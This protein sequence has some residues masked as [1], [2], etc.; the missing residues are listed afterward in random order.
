VLVAVRDVVEDA[1]DVGDADAA[2][3]RARPPLPDTLTADDV[4]ASCVAKLVLSL[5]SPK[6]SSADDE[7]WSVAPEAAGSSPVAPVHRHATTVP[8]RVI[9]RTF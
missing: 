6:R 9:C 5:V 7:L 3:L 8:N 4:H 2:W 1:A